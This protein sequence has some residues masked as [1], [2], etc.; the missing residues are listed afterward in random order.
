MKQWRSSDGAVTEQW[1]P[2]RCDGAVTRQWRSSDADG[3]VTE[4]WRISDGAVTELWRRNDGVVTKL[5][6]VPDLWRWLVTTK[7]LNHSLVASV[8]GISITDNL[9]GTICANIPHEILKRWFCEWGPGIV[10]MNVNHQAQV[11]LY[12]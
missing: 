11:F 6:S 2:R 8:D 12:T 4:E 9:N 1:R 7:Y 10:K 5:S 3:A